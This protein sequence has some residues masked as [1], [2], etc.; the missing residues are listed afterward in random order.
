MGRHAAGGFWLCKDSRYNVL[1]LVCPHGTHSRVST[2]LKTPKTERLVA[3]LSPTDK[4]L[5]ERA[6]DLEGRSLA[7][8]VVNHLLDVSREVI[9]QHAVIRL[10]ES[11]SLR[12]IQALQATPKKPTA[13]LRR[14]VH[15]YRQTV[16]EA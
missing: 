6:A 15:A 9:E 5:L 10:N 16:T 2:S 4:A 11:E 1:H 7:S 3:R 13:R 8:F 12:F 14:A